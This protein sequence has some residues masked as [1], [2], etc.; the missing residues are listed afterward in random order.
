M[1]NINLLPWREELRAQKQKD[2]LGLIIFSLIVAGAV[3]FG[4]HMHIS[5]LIE[6]QQNRNNFLVTETNILK[7]RVEEIK[8]LEKQREQL[9]N[10]MQVIQDLQASRSEVVNLF[11]QLVEIV[12][13]GIFIKSIQRNGKKLVVE[14]NTESN[15]RVSVMMRKIENSVFLE[16]PDVEYIVAEKGSNMSSFKMTFNQVSKDEEDAAK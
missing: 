9:I 6:Y 16:N 7:S 13:E 2:F 15:T 1:P 12:P 11:D 5:G 3:C 8:E 4:I 10:H 14:G